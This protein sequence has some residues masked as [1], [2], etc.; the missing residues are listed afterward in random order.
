MVD[1]EAQLV[2]AQHPFEIHAR[3]F[4]CVVA[5]SDAGGRR[6]AD[7]ADRRRAQVA[8]SRAFEIVLAVAGER[9]GRSRRTSPSAEK[10]SVR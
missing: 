3:R 7:V 2:I 10:L 1:A 4:A 8:D 9:H 6:A 5:R